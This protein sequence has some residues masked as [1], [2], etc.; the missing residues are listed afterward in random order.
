MNT[1]ILYSDET[2][3]VVLGNELPQKCNLIREIVG[4]HWGEAR[5]QVSD[6]EF[7]KVPG[8]GYFLPEAA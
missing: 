2:G 8:H 3:R 7:V 4:K 6:F 5:Q 1:Y